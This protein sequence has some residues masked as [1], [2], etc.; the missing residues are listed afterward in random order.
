MKSLFWHTHLTKM[1]DRLQSSFDRETQFTSDVSHELRTPISV[2][3]SQSQYGLKYVE[4]NDE[5][6]EIFENI[7]DESKKMTNLIS[8]LLMLS[9]MD[10][11][12][13]KLTIENTDLSEVVEI[14][15]E[16]KM[17]RQRKKI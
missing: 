16:M 4:I 12:S 10:K 6:R 17:E 11:G 5:T 9:R 3:S 2:I 7:L 1:F 8:K 13:Q 14:V 15:V